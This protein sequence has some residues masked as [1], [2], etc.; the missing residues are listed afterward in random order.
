[1]DNNTAIVVNLQTRIPYEYLGENKYRNMITGAEGVV[2]EEKARKIF[3]INLDT[4]ILVSEYPLVRDLIK[5]M[6]LRI[7]KTNNNE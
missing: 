1:M 4:T 3:A 7:E 2:D 6:Q 5:T